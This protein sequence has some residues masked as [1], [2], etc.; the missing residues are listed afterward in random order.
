MRNAQFAQGESRFLAAL[1]M[2][3]VLFALP[4]WGP[5]VLDPYKSTPKNTVRSDCATDT[6]VGLSTC[7]G[8]VC[9]SERS[10]ESAPHCS[11]AARDYF[12]YVASQSRNVLY[13][14]WLFCGFSTQCPSS[15]KT[16]SLEGTP[17]RCKALK[18]SS[19][20]VYGTR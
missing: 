13:Q 5:A 14:S 19:D 10:E 20:C 16:R 17:W 8:P 11:R 6:A 3:I 2:T 4:K 1:G 18:N 15:G 9:H 7:D 12:T